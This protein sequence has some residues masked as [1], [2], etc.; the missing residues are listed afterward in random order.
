M[1]RGGRLWVVSWSTRRLTRLTPEIYRMGLWLTTG[2]SA[3]RSAPACASDTG[4]LKIFYSD[5]C[6]NHFGKLIDYTH[7]ILVKIASTQFPV[8]FSK[9]DWKSIC[10]SSLL[11]P[12]VSVDSSMLAWGVQPRV[13]VEPDTTS[14]ENPLPV[15]CV[16]LI[17]KAAGEQTKYPSTMRPTQP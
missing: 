9:F 8:Y 1:E 5:K 17:L 16:T 10:T 4:K 11:S 6:E 14:S 15:N 3:R 7:L 12:T 13:T 2:V